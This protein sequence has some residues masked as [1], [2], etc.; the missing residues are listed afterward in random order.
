MKCRHKE[1][2]STTPG[3][4]VDVHL[5]TGGSS[6]CFDQGHCEN[7]A[8][9]KLLLY[10]RNKLMWKAIREVNQQIGTEAIRTAD[11]RIR[12]SDELYHFD[13]EYFPCWEVVH[14][15]ANNHLKATIAS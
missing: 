12:R 3:L 13:M 1:H 11:A 5:V 15:T 7:R 4:A 6:W 2:S 8:R 10:R 14:L 9:S